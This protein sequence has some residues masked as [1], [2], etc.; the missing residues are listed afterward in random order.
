MCKRIFLK[1][2]VAGG[3]ALAMSRLQAADKAEPADPVI[4]TVRGKVRGGVAQDFDARALEALGVREIHTKTQWLAAPADWSGVPLGKLL[5]SVGAS[6][7]TLRMRALNDYS[8][9]IPMA[10]IGRF[11]PVLANRLNGK[12]LS[13]RDRGPLIVIY[14]YDSFPELNTQVFYDRAVWQLREIVV[15]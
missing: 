15:E 14:P 9:T 2:L 4:L 13:V 11:N 10:D 12:T 8:V 6:G 7:D 3:A 5:A 1:S